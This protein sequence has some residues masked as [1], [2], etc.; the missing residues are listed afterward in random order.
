MYHT[1]KRLKMN[2]HISFF[3]FILKDR[4]NRKYLFIALAGMIA[5]FIIFKLLYPYADFFSDSYSYIYAAYANLDVSIWPIGYSKFLRIFHFITYSDTALVGFQYFFFELASLYFFFTILYFFNLGRV[6][7]IITF[8]FLF[9]NPLTLYV[10]NYVNSDPLFIALSLCWFTQLIWIIQRP[11]ISQIFIQAILLFACFTIRNNAY[12]YPVITAVAF[13]LSSYRLSLKV[14]G[15]LLGLL[16]ILPFI[17]Y[18]RNVAYKMTGTK[19]FSLFTGW[20][21]ANNILYAYEY[22][23]ASRNFPSTQSKEL[24][25]LSQQFYSSI[26]SDFKE[27]YL[28]KNP[29]NFFI[30]YSSAPLK[31][32]FSNHYKITDEYSSVVAWGKASVIFSEYAS[33][34]IK[35]NPT[36]YFHE[37]VIP[38]SKN[39]FIPHLEKLEVYNLGMNKVYPIARHWFHYKNVKISSVSPNIQ[40][41]ILFIFPFIFLMINLYLLGNAISFLIKNEYSYALFKRNGAFI[42][43]GCFWMA[44][45][46][47]CVGTTIVVLRYEV[48]PLIIGFS[49]TVL[50]IEYLN[51]RVSKKIRFNPQISG[52]IGIS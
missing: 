37:F 44:N 6:N 8:V 31:V 46:I 28:M 24:D 50:L 5:Q 15:T 52:E 32:Y 39:Y 3:D 18:T 33:Y 40:G 20:Q 30:Q 19:Q 12:Y 48:F 16:F 47:F 21:L 11:H 10:S 14:F 13:V 34:L 1:Q 23:D 4:T 38:N 7:Q 9:F 22:L 45:F 29:G 27:A 25:N 17:V 35:N 49:T 42:L 26:P 43:I 36:A 41:R 51:K 2:N